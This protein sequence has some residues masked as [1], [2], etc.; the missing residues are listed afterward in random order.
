MKGYAED[1]YW[2]VRTGVVGAQSTITAAITGSMAEDPTVASGIDTTGYTQVRL[3]CAVGGTAASW[4]ILPCYANGADST[5]HHGDAIQVATADEANPVFV[6]PSYGA[7]KFNVRA[8]NA[9]GT[10]PTL[11]VKATPIGG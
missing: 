11:T 1:G 4:T 6:V 7:S 2:D 10:S 8:Y 9:A 3:E 5:Y